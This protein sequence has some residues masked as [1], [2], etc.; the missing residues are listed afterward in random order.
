MASV[1]ADCKRSRIRIF[2]PEEKIFA[3][4]QDQYVCGY[5]YALQ[6]T[7]AHPFSELAKVEAPHVDLDGGDHAREV[8]AQQEA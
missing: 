6:T 8:E 2:T 7:G 4:I 3:R 5:F 1:R